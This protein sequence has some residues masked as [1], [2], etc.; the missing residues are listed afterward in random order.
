MLSLIYPLSSLLAIQATPGPFTADA[1]D[2]LAAARSAAAGAS[3]A[4]TGPSAGGA[5]PSAGGAAAPV[6]AA[7]PGALPR[8]Q[9]V[10]VA[11]AGAGAVRAL[12]E[13]RSQADTLCAEGDTSVLN[14]SCLVY[15]E[16]TLMGNVESISIAGLKRAAWKEEAMDCLPTCQSTALE[17]TRQ[18][19]ILKRIAGMWICDTAPGWLCDEKATRKAFCV[20]SLF[21]FIYASHIYASLT[22]AA[23]RWS[24]THMPEFL[25]YTPGVACPQVLTSER[26]AEA[27]EVLR[28]LDVKQAEEGLAKVR[29]K[30]QLCRTRYEARASSGYL[31]TRGEEGWLLRARPYQSC[32][33]VALGRGPG[34]AG[35][36]RNPLCEG[37]S[38]CSALPTARQWLG[39]QK[40][41]DAPLRYSL[42]PSMRF[43]ASAEQ[44]VSSFAERAL[45]S[46]RRVLWLASSSCAASPLLVDALLQRAWSKLCIMD[47]SSQTLNYP[48]FRAQAGFVA[49]AFYKLADALRLQSPL[50]PDALRG[51]ELY[52][53]NR[54]PG[55][56]DWLGLMVTTFGLE[57][58]ERLKAPVPTVSPAPPAQA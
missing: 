6:G 46:R 2:G 43:T 5:G 53:R 26:A 31:G 51:Y 25:F 49:G 15:V 39:T 9:A 56:Q 54:P 22:G 38:P 32:G 28:S 24:R 40:L 13:P 37:L 1:A 41:A 30:P 52:V 17:L 10:P 23:M 55:K 48:H 34:R 29:P 50:L 4:E 7:A 19:D 44:T 16:A 33:I 8:A 11:A 21:T 14:R 58:C 36:S 18:G 20:H 12:Q 57:A 35:A 47:H 27:D 3:E 45:P 42:L